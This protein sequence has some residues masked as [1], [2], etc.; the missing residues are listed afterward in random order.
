MPSAARRQIMG[1]DELKS[2]EA[3]STNFYPDFDML[4]SPISPLGLQE[5]LSGATG[6]HCHQTEKGFLDCGSLCLDDLP[7][8]LRFLPRDHSSSFYKLLKTLLF[9]RAWAGSASE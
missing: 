9:G 6:S 2:A 3:A 5:G 8:E 7:S 4:W 1:A